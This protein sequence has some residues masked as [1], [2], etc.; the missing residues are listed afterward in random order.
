MTGYL[1]LGANL[2]DRRASLA[3]AVLALDN[4]LCS[5]RVRGVF[6]SLEPVRTGLARLGARQVPER[7]TDPGHA[8]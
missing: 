1:A 7:R 3:A 8:A 5:D 4:W 6:H 2:G